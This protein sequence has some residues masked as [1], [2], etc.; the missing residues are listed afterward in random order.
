VRVFRF[1][2][3][4]L[5]LPCTSPKR[6]PE[7]ILRRAT[8]VALATL[9]ITGFGHA[10]LAQDRIDFGSP[11]EEVDLDALRGGEAALETEG[12]GV[13]AAAVSLAYQDVTN[14]LN[15]ASV[16]AGSLE[17]SGSLNDQMFVINSFNTAPNTV[18]QNTMTMT[19]NVRP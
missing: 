18:M 11:A 17:M 3:R 15:A 14:T 13:G 12:D 2:A 16:T 10:A 4:T 19:V 5:F 8:A 9:T 6:F 1:A 7:M